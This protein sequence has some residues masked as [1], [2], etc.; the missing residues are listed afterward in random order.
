VPN[1]NLS[2][3]FGVPFAP[4]QITHPFG[5]LALDAQP[6]IEPLGKDDKSGHEEPRS[7]QENR[8]TETI[9]KNDACFMIIVFE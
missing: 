2:T 8:K 7:W 4:L 3:R 6:M 5:T 1:G 9:R